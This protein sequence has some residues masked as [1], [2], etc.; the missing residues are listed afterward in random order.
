VRKPTLARRLHHGRQRLAE[1]LDAGSTV[2]P[3]MPT[4]PFRS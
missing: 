3:A 2:G 1:M 4:Y